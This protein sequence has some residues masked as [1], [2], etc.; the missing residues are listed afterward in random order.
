VLPP[1]EVLLH[2]AAIEERIYWKYAHA[3]CAVVLFYPNPNTRPPPET[4]A[5]A[6]PPLSLVVFLVSVYQ[7]YFVYFCPAQKTGLN[8]INDNKKHGVPLIIFLFARVP[9]QHSRKKGIKEDNRENLR[10]DFHFRG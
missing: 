3:S 4:V 7:V 5:I 9:V 1:V 8:H 10:C 2:R 6:P